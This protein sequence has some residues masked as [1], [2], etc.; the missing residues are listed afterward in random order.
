MTQ[1]DCFTVIL[2]FDVVIFVTIMIL[3]LIDFKSDFDRWSKK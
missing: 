1:I 3:S 2:C